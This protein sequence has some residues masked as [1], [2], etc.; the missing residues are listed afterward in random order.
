VSVEASYSSKMRCAF[1]GWRVLCDGELI[2]D[3]PAQNHC[4]MK[5]ALSI[6]QAIM[7]GV[8]RILVNV[9]DEP[10]IE[11]QWNGAGKQWVC[12]DYRQGKP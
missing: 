10:D 4:D 5:G 7:P 11:Y 1:T 12:Q 2:L 6:A 8:Y 3:L 9:D